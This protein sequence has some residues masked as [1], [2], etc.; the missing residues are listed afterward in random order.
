MRRYDK[1]DNSH[2]ALSIQAIHKHDVTESARGGTYWN[3]AVN[4]DLL[5]KAHFDRI[6]LEH[7]FFGC[8]D[9]R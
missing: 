9:E 3:L 6:G 5:C 8:T 4:N 2:L 7:G 1:C